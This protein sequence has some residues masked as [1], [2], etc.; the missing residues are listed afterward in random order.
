MFKLILITTIG[1]CYR[2]SYEVTQNTIKTQV[3]STYDKLTRMNRINLTKPII[4]MLSRV[5]VAD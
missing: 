1:L 3:I 4:L 5:A 2:K